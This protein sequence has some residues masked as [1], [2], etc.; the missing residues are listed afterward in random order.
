MSYDL[1]LYC[2]K[3]LEYYFATGRPDPMQ[4]MLPELNK[5]Y[6]DLI[7]KNFFKKLSSTVCVNMNMNNADEGSW[8]LTTNDC[9]HLNGGGMTWGAPMLSKW[10]K[11]E[12]GKD[13]L[14]SDFT[15]LEV[16][17]FASAKELSLPVTNKLAYH[18]WQRNLWYDVAPFW[19]VSLTSAF[20]E[21][22]KKAK[23]FF[24]TPKMFTDFIGIRFGNGTISPQLRKE[25][26][27]IKDSGT[28]YVFDTI[29]GDSTQVVVKG[30]EVYLSMGDPVNQVVCMANCAPVMAQ[31]NAKK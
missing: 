19:N 22:P 16:G 9:A 11:C 26:Q 13:L 1:E 15:P 29:P 2:G 12:Y 3:Q 5:K 17:A 20:T 21:V 7:C 30:D 23:P 27:A 28:T 18:T 25:M 24:Q 10:K 6:G 8:C 14:L 31:L 4:F